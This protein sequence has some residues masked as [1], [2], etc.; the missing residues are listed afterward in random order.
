MKDISI[1]IK[2]YKCFGEDAQGFESIFPMNIIIGRNNTGK[3]SLLDLIQYVT[4]PS[5]LAPYGHKGGEPEVIFRVKLSEPELRKVF[6]DI[7]TGGGVPGDNHWE[8]GKKLIGAKFTYSHKVKNDHAFIDLNPGLGGIH[9]SALGEFQGK[10]AKIAPNPFSLKTFMRLRSE[11][12]IVAEEDHDH[13][14]INEKGVGATRI[15]QSIINDVRHPSDLVETFLLG[16]LNKVVFPDAEFNDI[17]VQKIQNNL[18]EIYLEEAQKGRIALSDSGSGLK[19][20]ILVLVF[21]HLVPYIQNRK[22]SDYV[23][24]FEEVENNLHPAVQRR[25][26]N[27]LREFA[28]EKGVIFFITT[29]SN[30]VIDLFNADQEAQILHV[31]HDN[32]RAKVNHVETYVQRSGILDD[33]DIRASDILQSNGVVWVEGPSDRL[34]LNRWI[35]LWSEGTI[36]E[37]LHYQCVFYGGRL[38]AHLTAE[39]DETKIEDLIRILLIN[40]KCI[41]TMDSDKKNKGDKVDSSKQR[42]LDEFDDISTLCWMTQ[43][44]TIEN[45]IPNSA[46]EKLYGRGE[47]RQVDQFEDFSDYLDQI[48]KGEKEKFLNRK[49]LFAEKVCEFMDKESMAGVLDLKQRMDNVL[50]VI[51]GWNGLK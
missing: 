18:W 39:T 43:G 10:I 11:R 16:E 33:L 5:E 38:R 35:G 51:K 21:I 6:S 7:M 41:M 34:Y 49:F 24:G 20:I 2:Y 1:K 15:I 29:H 44:R 46:V 50:D 12:D 27:Y 19:T 28:L 3:S 4:R 22:V 47:L 14:N 8:Y 17:V 40:R 13:L 25:L 32:V 36:R 45:Y 37:G 30:V 23:F 26:F 9:P 48:Q 31:T 42:I